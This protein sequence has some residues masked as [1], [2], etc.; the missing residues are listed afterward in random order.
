MCGNLHLLGIVLLILLGGCYDPGTGLGQYSSLSACQ[1]VCGTP[2][3]SWDC[4]SQGCYDPGT[5]LGQYSSLADCQT[6]C[7]STVS[8]LCDSMTLIST[9]GSLQTVLSC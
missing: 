6:N 3:P 2:T 9:G 7:V 4:G 5:G 1:A 8:N